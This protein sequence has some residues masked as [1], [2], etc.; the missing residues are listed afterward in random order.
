MFNEKK[1]SKRK[2]GK[3]TVTSSLLVMSSF[4]LKHV[5]FWD[6]FSIVYQLKNFVFDS[7]KASAKQEQIILGGKNFPA[8]QMNRQ[9]N[10]HSTK[11]IMNGNNVS[12]SDIFVFSV[13]WPKLTLSAQKLCCYFPSNYFFRE[14]NTQFSSRRLFFSWNCPW[15][16]EFKSA[17]SLVSCII[18]VLGSHHV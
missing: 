1:N 17:E 11:Y 16:A 18:H 3:V 10:F 13:A 4:R 9:Q 14:K 2:R 7:F 5:N 8:I 12:S 15:G 6:F